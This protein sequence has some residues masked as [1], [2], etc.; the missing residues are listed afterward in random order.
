VDGTG[1]GPGTSPAAGLFA[2]TPARPRPAFALTPLADVMFQLLI[3]F[4]LSSSLAPYALL[5]MGRGA[6]PPA[7]DAPAPAPAPEQ[8]AA[9]PVWQLGRGEARA[10]TERFALDEAGARLAALARDGRAELMVLTTSAARTADVVRLLEAVQTTARA[11][12]PMQVRLVGQQTPGG[13]AP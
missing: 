1:S 12:L 13:A 9:P 11:G 10:G 3:F 2:R 4:M 6:G 8:A 7:E 5:P